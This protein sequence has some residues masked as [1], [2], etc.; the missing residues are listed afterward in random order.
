MT[1]GNCFQILHTILALEA[2]EGTIKITRTVLTPCF[3]VTSLYYAVGTM[4]L[5]FFIFPKN[6][7][8]THPLP[9]TICIR[10]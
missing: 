2:K 10:Y 3:T 1:D 9:Q 7:F 5:L 8:T 4:G 6:P